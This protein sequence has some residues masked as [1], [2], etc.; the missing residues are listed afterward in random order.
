MD[1]PRI[2]GTIEAIEKHLTR[3]G[4]VDRYDSTAG[5][6][7]LPPGEGAFLACSFWLVT[8]LWLIGRHA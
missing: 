5:S 8:D 7:G 6:D 2:V 1:D 3:D 4:F